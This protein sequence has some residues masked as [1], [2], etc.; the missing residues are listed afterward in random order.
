MP[1]G[2]F[3]RF[4]PIEGVP[5]LIATLARLLGPNGFA[6]GKRLAWNLAVGG[7]QKKRFQLSLSNDTLQFSEGRK[8]YQNYKR[9]KAQRE[10][11]N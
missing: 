1:V 5:Y 9:D 6:E 10:E 7:P 4:G 8:W 2:R 3:L 11:F